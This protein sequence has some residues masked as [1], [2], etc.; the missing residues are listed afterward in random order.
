MNE[1]MRTLLLDDK[2]TDKHADEVSC[3]DADA[4]YPVGSANSTTEG[5]L[6]LRVA[7][8]SLADNGAEDEPLLRESQRRFVLFPIQYDDVR[9]FSPLGLFSRR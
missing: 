2:N 6:E 9:S 4:G 1:S 7:A 5:D 3:K 8:V